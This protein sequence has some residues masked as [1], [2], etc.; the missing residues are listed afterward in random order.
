MRNQSVPVEYAVAAGLDAQAPRHERER[1]IIEDLIARDNRYKAR[2]REM[3]EL[4]VEAKRLALSSEPPDKILDLIAQKL[5]ARH[6]EET[7]DP[8]DTATETEQQQQLPTTAALNA[9]ERNA[10]VQG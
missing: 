4:I 1:R 7:A 6:I 9:I 5:E 10:A 8:Q 2:S 3:A